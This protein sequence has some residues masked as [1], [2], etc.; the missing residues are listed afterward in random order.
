MN[1]DAFDICIAVGILM[2]GVAALLVGA[3]F[4]IAVLSQ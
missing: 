1:Y 3:S 4:L 2:F